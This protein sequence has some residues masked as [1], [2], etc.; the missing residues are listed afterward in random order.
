MSRVG[1]ASAPTPPTLTHAFPNQG[2]FKL[3]EMINQILDVES[4]SANDIG[5]NLD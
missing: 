5:Y 3:N 2:L 4:H 1:S